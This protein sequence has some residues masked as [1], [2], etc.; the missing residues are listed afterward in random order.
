MHFSDLFR[1]I[2][3]SGANRGRPTDLAEVLEQIK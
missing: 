1:A 2:S 3:R